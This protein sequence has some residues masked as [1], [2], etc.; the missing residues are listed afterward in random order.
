MANNMGTGDDL[1]LEP[2]QATNPQPCQ[3]PAYAEH[4]MAITI[5]THSF[6]TGMAK[7]QAGDAGLKPKWT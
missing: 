7:R 5:L 1:G 6:E 2:T 4:W 3:D